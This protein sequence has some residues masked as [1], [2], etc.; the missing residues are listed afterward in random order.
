MHR[1]FT[2]NALLSCIFEL[3]FI[4]NL[5]RILQKKKKGRRRRDEEGKKKGRRREEEG[6]KKG[7]KGIIMIM[8]MRKKR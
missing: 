4:V 7:R 8:I 2:N 6:K 5:D 1:K 3:I